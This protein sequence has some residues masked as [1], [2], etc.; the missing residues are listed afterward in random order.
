MIVRSSLAQRRPDSALKIRHGFPRTSKTTEASRTARRLQIP[1]IS[2]VVSN[3]FVLQTLGPSHHRMCSRGNCPTRSTRAFGF[4]DLRRREAVGRPEPK[5]GRVGRRFA[6]KNP[7]NPRL[8]AG[9]SLRPGLPTA[10]ETITSIN[11]RRRPTLHRNS[12]GDP[13]ILTQLPA[14][15]ECHDSDPAKTEP[16]KSTE[17]RD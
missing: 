7:A 4:V 14:N 17:R 8:E 11:H 12:F 2:E 3:P 10:T 16:L 1:G 6:A 9:P 13:L 5:I 15:L